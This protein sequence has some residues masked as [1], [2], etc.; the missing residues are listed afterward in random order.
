M[1]VTLI[2]KEGEW[3]VPN[4]RPYITC[5]NNVYKLYTSILL[6]K[7]QAHLKEN[8]L[9]QIDK[10]GGKTNCS[11]TIDNLLVDETVPRD[12]RINHRNLS[13]AWTY[14]RKAFDSLSNGYLKRMIE[15]HRVPAKLSGSLCSVINN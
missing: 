7:L 13:C 14:V 6:E 5:S 10:L 8:C 15:I 9:I 1:K 11:G 2:P 3:S 12:E 4:H